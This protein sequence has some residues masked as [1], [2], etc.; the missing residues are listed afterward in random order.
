[1]IDENEH[2]TIVLEKIAKHNIKYVIPFHG[3][4]IATDY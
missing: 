2:N 4:I 3:P 1:M